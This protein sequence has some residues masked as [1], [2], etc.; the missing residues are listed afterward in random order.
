[1]KRLLIA[2]MC[3][4]ILCG[5]GEAEV[6]EERQITISETEEILDTAEKSEELYFSENNGT[7]EE[8]AVNNENNN[9]STEFSWDEIEETVPLIT[10]SDRMLE[11]YKNQKVLLKCILT[12]IEYVGLADSSMS[13]ELWVEDGGFYNNYGM[14][15]ISLEDGVYG[16]EDLKNAGNGDSFL[17]YTTIYEDGSIATTEIIAVKQ[18]EPEMDLVQLEDSYKAHC[19]LLDYEEVLRNPDQYTNEMVVVSGKILQV[20]ENDERNVEFLLDTEKDNEIVYISGDLAEGDEGILEGDS[21]K[22]YGKVTKN[23]KS[24]ISIW[25]EEKTVV[26][27][28]SQFI[29]R[30]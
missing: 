30:Q 19:S 26:R 29:E 21:I 1:M 6:A 13:F 14:G 22:A 12:D 17:F 18:I 27:V 28:S 20:L 4:V 5:C 16:I 8:V 3:S 15:L 10:F 24:Y 2:L 9:N 11:D 25:G 7:N 23:L